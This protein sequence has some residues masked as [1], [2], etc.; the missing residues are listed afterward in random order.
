MAGEN[1]DSG[2][3]QFDDLAPLGTDGNQD[4]TKQ[5]DVG[6]RGSKL[7]AL[8]DEHLQESDR[9]TRQAPQTKKE[10]KDGTQR[11][12]ETL[13][14]PQ[15]QGTNQDDRTQRRGQG[16]DRT[17]QI[18]QDARPPRPVG[19][20]FRANGDGSIYDLQGRKVANVG[21]E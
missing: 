20:M 19:S 14:A 10:G 4:G 13:K 6:E 17:Q 1:D 3:D 15:G 12:Q 5:D 11:P 21:L 18:Q 2:S 7:D 16:D 9:G 8:L